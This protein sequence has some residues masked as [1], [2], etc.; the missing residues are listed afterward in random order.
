MENE[1]RDLS[2]GV[3]MDGNRRWAKQKN[4]E[5]FEGHNAGYVVFKNF[6]N[7]SKELGVKTV[8]SYVF[9]EE[10]WR[11]TE[12]EVSFLLSLMK[13]VVFEEAENFIKE[14]VR[15]IFAGNISKFP[16]DIYEKMLEIQERTKENTDFNLVLC[17]SYGGRSEIV[18][19]VNRFLEKNSNTSFITEND[20]SENIYSSGL[21]DPDLIIR[22]SGEQRLS[23]F[24]PWQSIYS[25]LFFTNTLW[26]DFTK[27]EFE[28]ILDQY[29]KRQRRMGK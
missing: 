22:T 28:S 2:V 9:S 26:P 25:E 17:L 12:N 27:E 7:W 24:L 14:K 1:N 10:N 20:I 6:L 3:I 15:V 5:S 16:K 18:S 29:T 8:Y 19:A 13:K 23:G 21:S 11:R 4:K